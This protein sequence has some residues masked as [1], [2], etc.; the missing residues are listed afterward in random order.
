MNQNNK[1]NKINNTISRPH[2]N[3]GRTAAKAE[4]LSASP[5]DPEHVF[6]S[7]HVFSHKQ[8]TKVI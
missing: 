6:D 4:H 7:C 2:R 3:P 5:A 1:Q 8:T